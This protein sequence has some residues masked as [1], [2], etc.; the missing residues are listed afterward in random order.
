MSDAV[1]IASCGHLDP[2]RRDV[3][4]V[5]GVSESVDAGSPGVN[6]STPQ[7]GPQPSGRSASRAPWRFALR[8]LARHKGPFA[9][10]LFWSVVFIL[11]PMQVPVITGALVDSLRAKHARLYGVGLDSGSRSRSVNIAALALMGVALAHGLSAYLRQLSINKLT[12]R[13]V[14][15]TRQELIQRLT[16]MPLERH[17]QFGAAELF[18]RV[19]SDT[20]RLRSFADQVV[21][22]T[23]TNALRVA[24]PVTLLFLRQPLLAA[25]VC[26]PI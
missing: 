11:V 9:L 8:R 15:E 24:F 2:A 16:T 17:F 21:I 20:A 25:V 14:C 1:P 23:A 5:S 22:R 3:E 7:N 6:R 10:A 19:I 12:G 13:F 26:A 18:H 4:R